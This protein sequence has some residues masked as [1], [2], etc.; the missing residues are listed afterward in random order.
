MPVI[1]ICA[2]LLTKGL[3]NFFTETRPGR[4][5]SE[6]FRKKVSCS[7]QQIDLLILWPKLNAVAW[8]PYRR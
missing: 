4:R 2:C 5:N 6:N 1:E 7:H 3:C 8:A